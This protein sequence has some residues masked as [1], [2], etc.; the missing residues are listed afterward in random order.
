MEQIVSKALLSNTP[1][2]MF[3]M[4]KSV[5]TLY[6]NNKSKF[7]K[8]S[9]EFDHLVPPLINYLNR[10]TSRALED[11]IILVIKVIGLKT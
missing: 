2:L 1:D 9:G 5:F 10:D 11:D 4:I 3:S 7:T 8:L 6:Q